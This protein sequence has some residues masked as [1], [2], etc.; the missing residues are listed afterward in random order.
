MPWFMACSGVAISVKAVIPS[1]PARST[2]SG[3]E[4]R[5]R[6]GG[7]GGGVKR[8]RSE[9]QRVREGRIW[10]EERDGGWRREGRGGVTGRD[11]QKMGREMRNEGKRREEGQRGK[12]R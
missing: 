3:G 12:Q 1:H 2:G 8:W 9:G 7:G 11:G 4:E 10:R 5:E 6:G